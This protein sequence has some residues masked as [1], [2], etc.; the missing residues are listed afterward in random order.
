MNKT[1]FPKS[2]ED[3]QKIAE[4]YINDPHGLSYD[5]GEPLEAL[6]PRLKIKHEHSLY[7]VYC[8][9]LCVLKLYLEE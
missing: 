1:I 5:F 3:A 4:E 7:R 2:I 8:D 9:G 6:R